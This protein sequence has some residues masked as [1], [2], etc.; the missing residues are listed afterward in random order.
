MNSTFSF[1]LKEH[2]Q[3]DFL[4]SRATAALFRHEIERQLIAHH[5]VEIDFTGVS[6]T[7]SFTDELIGVIAYKHGPTMLKQITFKGCSQ[8]HKKIIQ[9]VVSHRLSTRVDLPRAMS[10]TRSGASAISVAA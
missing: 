8:E 4:A 1:L 9:F 5:P 6:I 2:S 3:K 7:Q 10:A